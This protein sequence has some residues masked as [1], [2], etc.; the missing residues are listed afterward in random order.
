MA[1]NSLVNLGS[2]ERAG[3]PFHKPVLEC[4]ECIAAQPKD[5]R[6]VM[7]Q[8]GVRDAG[9]TGAAAGSTFDKVVSVIKEY[10]PVL[11]EMEISESH[12][13]IEDLKYDSLG[14]VSLVM[15]IEDEFDFSEQ[16][17]AATGNDEIAELK[18]VGDLVRTVYKLQN[19]EKR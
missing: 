12:H 17:R 13:L 3:T 10:D 9:K 2:K 4:T 15:A 5:S 14:K 8:L 18:T 1:I 6:F 16:Q 7:S 19:D 11:A